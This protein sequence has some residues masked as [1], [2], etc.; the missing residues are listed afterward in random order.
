MISDKVEIDY[1]ICDDVIFINTVN[2]KYEYR[3]QGIFKNLLNQLQ[4]IYQKPI[5]LESF[6]TLIPMYIH[7]GFEDLGE[8]DDSGYHLMKRNYI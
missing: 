1:T 7:L 2:V 8:S 6:H 5:A 3:K 4:Q